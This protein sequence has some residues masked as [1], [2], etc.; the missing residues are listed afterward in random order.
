MS[1]TITNDGPVRVVTLDRPDVRNAV[2]GEHAQALYDAFR[3]F[4]SDDSASVAVLHGAGGV[5]CAGADL[6]A[7]SR[8]EMPLPG[9]P[10]ADERGPMGPTRLKLSKPVIAA[11]DGYAVAGGLELALWCDLRVADPAATFGV[12]CRRWGVPL[13]DGGTVR[14]PRLVGFG[15]AMDLI[16]TGRAV[17]ADE[18]LRIGL[19]N[20]VS[21]PGRALEEAVLLAHELAALPQLCLRGDRL[22]TYDSIGLSHDAAMAAEWERG[23]ISLREAATGAARFAGGEGRHGSST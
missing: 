18:A 2:D 5:F 23:L 20:R 6:G 3:A 17:G 8:G 16:L 10:N 22:S 11:V 4:D 14:L 12:F 15:V 9:T 1:V 19:A 7:V 13:I 21:E